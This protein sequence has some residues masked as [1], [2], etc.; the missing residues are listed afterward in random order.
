MSLNLLN[1]LLDHN[2]PGWNGIAKVGSIWA[3]P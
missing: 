1:G 2:Y 3:S